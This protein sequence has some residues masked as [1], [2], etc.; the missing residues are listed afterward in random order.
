MVRPKSKRVEKAESYFVKDEGVNAYTCLVEG[1]RVKVKDAEGNGAR[2]RIQHLERK[3]PELLDGLEKQKRARNRDPEEKPAGEQN[4]EQPNSQQDKRPWE[5]EQEVVD[6]FARNPTLPFTHADDK[7]FRVSAVSRH[8]LPGKLVHRSKVLFEQFLKQIRGQTVSVCIDSGKNSGIKT[9]NVVV[10]VHR[11][12]FLIDAAQP[13]DHTAQS[14]TAAVKASLANFEDITFAGFVADNASNMQSALKSLA[15]DYRCVFSSCA[16]HS[17]NLLVKR[18]VNDETAV[19]EANVLMKTVRATN[20]Q[21]PAEVDTRFV[22]AYNGLE[23][24]VKNRDHLIADSVLTHAEWDKI[25]AGEERIGLFNFASR[26][27]EKD[28]ATIFDVVLHCAKLFPTLDATKNR[29]VHE[30]YERDFFC[31]AL[32]AAAAL[33]PTLA[34]QN[35]A[36]PIQIMIDVSISKLLSQTTN[37]LPRQIRTEVTRIFDGASQ[38]QAARKATPTYSDAWGTG[39]TP[40]TN[41]LC[42][43]LLWLPA[44]SA[45][46]E[47][48]FSVLGRVLN[49]QRTAIAQK[50]LT[51]QVVAHS[52]LDKTIHKSTLPPTVPTPFE[53]TTV[54]DAMFPCFSAGPASKLKTGDVVVVWLNVGQNTKTLGQFKARLVQF[55]REEWKVR[56]HGNPTS[57]QTF[58]PLVDIWE[59]EA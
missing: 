26:A 37:G 27:L 56:W 1:C 32:I 45:S 28:S 15:A 59:M 2:G 30:I 40:L 48:S 18:V 44:S 8:N 55:E 13:E 12:A 35:L 54:L 11:T 43:L 39:D 49:P 53:A 38:L 58:A 29:V 34:V 31:D 10:L 9:L 57:T 24:A 14:I 41:Q 42:N 20:P 33:N 52:M 4:Q 21:C 50:N 5:V 6:Y 19:A 22:S 17:V 51:A 3:H 25:K 16:C 46:V 47:R 36:H 23:W 7:L